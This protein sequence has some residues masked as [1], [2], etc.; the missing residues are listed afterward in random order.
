VY[1]E[2]LDFHHTRRP[3]QNQAEVVGVVQGA[4]QHHLLFGYASA[5]S[6]APTSPPATIPTASA[7]TGG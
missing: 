5:T 6:T 4:G 2:P 3:I 1:R 7:A